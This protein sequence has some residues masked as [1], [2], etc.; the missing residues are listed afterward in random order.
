LI[1]LAGVSTKYLAEVGVIMV[2][3]PVS[4]INSVGGA[5]GS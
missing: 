5:G 4:L 1:R 3:T 2:D